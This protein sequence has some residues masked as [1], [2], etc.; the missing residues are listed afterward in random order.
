MTMNGIVVIMSDIRNLHRFQCLYVHALALPPLPKPT[1]TY[2]GITTSFIR[3]YQSGLQ[4]HST[5]DKYSVR[6]LVSS[7][8]STALSEKEL[9]PHHQNWSVFSIV[10]KVDIYFYMVLTLSLFWISVCVIC[11]YHLVLRVLISAFFAAVLK[12]FF[13]SFLFFSLSKFLISH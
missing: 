10:W 4:K 13:F 11:I 3:L 6:L 2:L 12:F 9:T 5:F 7:T 8:L 1:F